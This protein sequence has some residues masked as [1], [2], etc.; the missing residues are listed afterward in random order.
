MLTEREMGGAAED[1]IGCVTKRE[2]RKMLMW[3]QEMG[4]VHNVYYWRGPVRCKRFKQP[5]FVWFCDVV[6]RMDT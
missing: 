1:E 2:A 4:R 6:L 5:D 3:K